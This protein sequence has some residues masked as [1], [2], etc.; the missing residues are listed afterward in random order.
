[1]LSADGAFTLSSIPQTFRHLALIVHTRATRAAVDDGVFIRFNDDTGANHDGTQLAVAGTGVSA[2]EFFRLTIIR[3]G[4]V[5][6]ATAATTAG[7]A[8]ICVV[9]IPDYARTTFQK[10]TLAGST[11]KDRHRGQQRRPATPGRLLA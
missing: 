4:T 1:M 2:A 5:P 11:V 3:I 7:P 10:S 9:R 6:A 8:G